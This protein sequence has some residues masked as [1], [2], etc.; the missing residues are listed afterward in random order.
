[1]A[2]ED[3][4]ENGLWIT[5]DFVAHFDFGL[6]LFAINVRQYYRAIGYG[7]TLTCHV[8][9]HQIVCIQ[10]C[11]TEARTCCVQLSLSLST[12]PD[13]CDVRCQRNAVINEINMN[14]MNEM[15]M[16]FL[17]CKNSISFSGVVDLVVHRTTT[18]MTTTSLRNVVF[19]LLYFRSASGLQ[20]ICRMR[21]YGKIRFDMTDIAK[22][23]T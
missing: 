15:K 5:F 3:N 19:F 17:C 11:K 7:P 18:T 23:H 9:F 16:E 22:G 4:K 6:S 12:L 2:G 14:E 10:C 20:A 21:R 8:C 13:G 1:M